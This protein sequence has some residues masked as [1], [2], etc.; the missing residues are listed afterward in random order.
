MNVQ[1]GDGLHHLL[2]HTPAEKAVLDQLHFMDPEDLLAKE[3]RP[4][5]N[6]PGHALANARR[7]TTSRTGIAISSCARSLISGAATFAV[8]C[9][10]LI[11]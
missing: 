1:D 11:V 10:V 5:A 2:P 7:L 3:L 4:L 8:Q 9:K 6:P